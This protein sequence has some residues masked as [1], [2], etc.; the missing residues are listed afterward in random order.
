MEGVEEVRGSTNKRLIW[1]VEVSS[2]T[3]DKE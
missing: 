1:T 2:R 3:E